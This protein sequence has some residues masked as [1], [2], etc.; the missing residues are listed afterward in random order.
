MNA[1]RVIRKVILW[2]HTDNGRH[3]AV[4]SVWGLD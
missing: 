2:Y 1:D 4:V 3:R